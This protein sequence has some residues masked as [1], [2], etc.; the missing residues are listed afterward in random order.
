LS[1]YLRHLKGILSEAGIKVTGENRARVDE[2]FHRVT[3][4]PEG[5]CPATWKKLKA[6]WLTTPEKKRALAAELRAALK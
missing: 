2:A 5:E 3:G 1:C 4:V 6:D